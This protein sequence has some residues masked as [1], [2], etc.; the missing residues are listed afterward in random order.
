MNDR[1]SHNPP[2]LY[3][4]ILAGGR[5]SRMGHD[6][7]LIVYHQKPQREYLFD[8]L[9]KFSTN[10]YTSCK[11]NDDIPP[12]L[13]PLPDQFELDSPLNGIM[14]AFKNN[15]T[16]AWLCIAV[17]MPLIDE[18]TIQHLVD[19]RSTKHLATCFFDSDGTNPEPLFTIWEPAAAPL[20]INFFKT[21][22]KSPRDFLRQSEIKLIK[23]TNANVLTNVN[24]SEELKKFFNSNH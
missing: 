5:S 11:R 1:S 7:S 3:A 23:T 18:K 22:K 16:V 19:N 8:L 14:S 6:K 12:H 2:P 20:L 10:V 15:A 9:R 17:D 4:L 21:G 24:S 13:N